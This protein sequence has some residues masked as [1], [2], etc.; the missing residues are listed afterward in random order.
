MR[1]HNSIA[2]SHNSKTKRRHQSAVYIKHIPNNQHP[3]RENLVSVNLNSYKKE[4]NYQEELALNLE[5]SQKEIENLR[6]LLSERNELIEKQK[7]E[8]DNQQKQLLKLNESKLNDL[9]YN[10]QL[11]QQLEEQKLVIVNLKSKLSKLK[12]EGNLDSDTMSC[13]S[14]TLDKVRQN[15]KQNFKNID[16]NNMSSKANN[17]N[18]RRSCIDA[19][20]QATETNMVTTSELP[21]LPPPPPPVISSTTPEELIETSLVCNIPE[22]HKLEDLVHENRDYISKLKAQLKS[23]SN[24]DE[25]ML[26]EKKAEFEA[27]DLAINSRKQ[28]LY[29]LE[30][31]KNK[32]SELNQTSSSTSNENNHSLLKVKFCYFCIREYQKQIY[33]F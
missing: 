18:R 14:N 4:P 23:E 25:M 6:L 15:V 8:H 2:I 12:T 21:P 1:H 13:I 5:K 27:L 7:Q 10:D 26:L 11:M 3:N 33:T 16:E 29:S 32:L 9:K 28:Q 17:N 22:H 31:K 19:S 30:M 20:V 24:F